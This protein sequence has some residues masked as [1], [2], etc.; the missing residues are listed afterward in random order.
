MHVCCVESHYQFICVFSQ[1]E[2]MFSGSRY[3]YMF[4]E[5]MKGLWRWETSLIQTDMCYINIMAYAA[6]IYA[7]TAAPAPVIIGRFYYTTTIH[8]AYALKGN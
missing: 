7:N 6:E 8:L 2:M 5:Q 4:S 1:V 3:R